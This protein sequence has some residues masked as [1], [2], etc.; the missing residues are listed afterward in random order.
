MYMVIFGD[1]TKTEDKIYYNELPLGNFTVMDKRNPTLLVHT[2]ASA[3]L[4]KFSII[5]N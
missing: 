3:N 5:G 1:F 2:D 4:Y